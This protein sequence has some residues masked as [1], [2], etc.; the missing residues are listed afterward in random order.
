LMVRGFPRRSVAPLEG[1]SAPHCKEPVC[2]QPVPTLSAFLCWRSSSY[3]WPHRPRGDMVYRLRVTCLLAIT[4]LM[5]PHTCPMVTPAP[6]RP[7]L[8]LGPTYAEASTATALPCL[9]VKHFLVFMDSLADWRTVTGR[10]SAW[11]VRSGLQAGGLDIVKYP[12]YAKDYGPFL[13]RLG[14]SQIPKDSPPQPGDISVLQPGLNPSGHVQ[15]WDGWRWVS[16]FMQ[17][18]NREKYRGKGYRDIDALYALYRYPKPC[19]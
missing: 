4:Y 11:A 15:V 17:P 12:Y 6:V 14:F 16:D 5:V 13:V 18:L 10:E 9:N 2:G 19:Q 3:E 1:H 8:E 7:R